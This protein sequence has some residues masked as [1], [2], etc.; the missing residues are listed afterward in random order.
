[1]R[2]IRDPVPP[3]H[4]TARHLILE[5]MPESGEVDLDKVREA[6]D[7]E[8]KR[9]GGTLL[10]VIA[11]TTAL[12]AAIAAVASLVAGS[13]VNEAL[14]LKQEATQLQSRA[15]D[16]W[17]YYQAKGVKS[18]IASTAVIGIGSTSRRA[19]L[20]SL[21][22]LSARY[23]REQLAVADTARLLEH[24][25]D[26]RSQQADVLLRRHHLY[27]YSVALLQVAIALGAVAALTRRRSIWIF[28]VLIG[29]GGTVLLAIGF[30]GSGRA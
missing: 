28:S 25:R 26:V 4:K 12:L 18:A 23:A 27:A 1:M 19:T 7:E 20:D 11:L 21:A 14:V 5:S 9:E 22:A 3:G 15:S 29:T 10:R 17:A 2:F 30:L 6:I 8:L 16:E 24:D 13:S